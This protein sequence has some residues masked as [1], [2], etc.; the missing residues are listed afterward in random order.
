M[1]THLC[2]HGQQYTC[3]SFPPPVGVCIAPSKRSYMHVYASLSEEAVQKEEQ[4]VTI[5]Y[6]KSS[7]YVKTSE[8]STYHTKLL[9]CLRLPYTDICI[10]TTRKHIRAITTKFSTEH[11]GKASQLYKTSAK[12]IRPI[13]ENMRIKENLS[14]KFSEEYL[15]IL[16]V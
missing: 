9:R 3:L 16:F 4:N 11:P 5:L 12:N 6:R 13:R 7:Y 14:S 15:C 1:H 2:R 10:I 8:E